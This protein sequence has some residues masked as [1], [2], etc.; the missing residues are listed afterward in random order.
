MSLRHAELVAVNRDIE[1]TTAAIAA[2]CCGET[3]YQAFAL[4][5]GGGC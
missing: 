3:L 1:R 5:H 4:I 2:F